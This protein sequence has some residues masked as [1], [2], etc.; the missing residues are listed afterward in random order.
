M[1]IKAVFDECREDLSNAGCKRNWSEILGGVICDQGLRDQ[2]D[3]SLF[4]FLGN[5]PVRMTMSYR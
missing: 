4:P 5:F 1:L 3:D 2:L